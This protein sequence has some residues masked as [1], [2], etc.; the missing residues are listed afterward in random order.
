[1]AGP[2]ADI[3]FARAWIVYLLINKGVDENDERQ[4]TLERFIRKQCHACAGDTVMLVVAAL[5]YL[6]D[7][8]QSGA[9][10]LE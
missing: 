2:D 8:D 7:L 6:K 10:S 9:V 1:M 4:A 5:K 3:A